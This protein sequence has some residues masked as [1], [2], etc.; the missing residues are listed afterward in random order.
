ME[1][2]EKAKR[3]L[4]DSPPITPAQFVER[5]WK[6]NEV[7]NVEDAYII[8]CLTIRNKKLFG[9]EPITFEILVDRYTN[10]MRHCRNNATPA[11]Y[12]IRIENFMIK[13][14]YNTVYKVR[15]PALSKRFGIE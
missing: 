4:G 14:G 3:L 10:Y 6:Q 9:G 15:N 1:L 2:S 13:G 7:G 11:K 5:L 12:I 8:T